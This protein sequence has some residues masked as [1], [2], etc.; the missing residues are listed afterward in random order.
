MK[1]YYDR[2]LTLREATKRAQKLRR[3]LFIN[4]ASYLCTASNIC[5]EERLVAPY[6]HA[7][8]CKNDYEAAM[9]WLRE[10]LG[11]S[12]IL[13]YPTDLSDLLCDFQKE[14]HKKIPTNYWGEDA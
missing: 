13:L 6:L 4:H 3:A 12:D 14:L 11:E 5:P 8:L 7:G 10:Y 1:N 9:R 2:P